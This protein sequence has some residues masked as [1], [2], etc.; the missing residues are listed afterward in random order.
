MSASPFGISWS[1]VDNKLVQEKEIEKMEITLKDNTERFPINGKDFTVDLGDIAVLEANDSFLEFMSEV[2]G[3]P[4]AYSLSDIHVKQLEFITAAL[5]PSQVSIIE[6]TI[7]PIDYTNAN[8]LSTA[9]LRIISDHTE[10]NTV[11]NI[12]DELGIEAKTN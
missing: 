2:A 1:L 11:D 10:Q 7:F 3:D 9:L 8:I 4:D 12:L 5:G 6:T